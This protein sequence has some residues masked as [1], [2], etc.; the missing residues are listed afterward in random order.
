MVAVVV[1]MEDA[2]C[3]YG[4]KRRGE[5][6]RCSAATLSSAVRPSLAGEFEAVYK[7]GGAGRIQILGLGLGCC[8]LQIGRLPTPRDERERRRGER[9]PQRETP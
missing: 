7:R 8:I 1:V 4:E 3:C 9:H 5:K 2:F 6:S